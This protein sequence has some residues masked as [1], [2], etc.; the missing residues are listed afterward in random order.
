MSLG[1][2]SPMGRSGM[3]SSGHTGS[4]LVAYFPS[5]TTDFSDG[6]GL[7]LALPSQFVANVIHI[8]FDQIDPNV[9]SKHGWVQ[10]QSAVDTTIQ[11][12]LDVEL[13]TIR[14]RNS[15]LRSIQ[16]DLDLFVV[17]VVIFVIINF[18]AYRI[19]HTIF[20]LLRVV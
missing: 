15:K 11:S 18:F 7:A 4:L 5:A 19:H 9:R 12:I 6:F 1:T 10:P 2:T 13:E 8:L 16:I 17:I 14:E 20:C 3:P